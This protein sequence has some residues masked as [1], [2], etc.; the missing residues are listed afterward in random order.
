MYLMYTDVS[1]I[2]LID[3]KPVQWLQ[4]KLHIFAKTPTY[5]V[6]LNRWNELWRTVD[7]RLLPK[8]AS[9]PVCLALIRDK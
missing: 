7:L 2:S 6:C 8:R 9:N 1:A 3:P 4:V 5:Y